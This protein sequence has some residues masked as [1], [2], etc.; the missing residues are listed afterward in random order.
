VKREREEGERERE[1][2]ST[3][4]GFSTRPAAI[5]VIIWQAEFPLSIT[6]TVIV[7]SHIYDHILTS[8]SSMHHNR[9][10][11]TIRE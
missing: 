8:V 4:S 5:V 10:S 1:R 6:T 9:C 11:Y 2:T 3:G 7:I